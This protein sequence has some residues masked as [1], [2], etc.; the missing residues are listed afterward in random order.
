ML[1]RG[2]F[3][4]AVCL[5]I[6][7]NFDWVVRGAQPNIL[8]IAIDDLNDWTGS[9]GGHPQA[10][11]PNLDRLAARGLQFNNAHCQSPI[12]GPSRNSLLT[13][14]FP[15]TSGLYFL[16]PLDIR[17]IDSLKAAVTLPQYF[18][19]HGYE[20]LA[21]GKVF[22]LN[23]DASFPQYG[24]DFGRLGPYPEKRISYHKGSKNVDWGVAPF[25]DEAMPDTKVA[26]W[27]IDQL[28]KK[29]E[30]PFFLGCG[31]FRPHVPWYVGKKWFDAFP[32][33]SV[34]LPETLDSDGDDISGYA[35][36]LTFSAS[37]PRHHWVVENDE[38]QHSVQAYLASI[39]FVD[40]QLGRVLDALEASEYAENTLIVVWSDHGY[41][42]GEKQ[43]WAKRSL[44]EESTKVPLIFAGPRIPQEQEVDR[45]VGLIDLYPTLVEYA[46]LPAKPH[47]DGASLVPLIENPMA[48][49]SRPAVT[50]FGPHNH[51]IRSERW[52]YIRYADGSEELY[53]HSKDPHEWINLAGKARFN[54]IID[55]HAAWLPQV[56]APLVAGSADSDS[57]IYDPKVVYQPNE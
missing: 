53:D 41:H 47:L 19:K 48:A 23:D 2:V 20:A 32:R 51:A 45:P 50:T 35:R 43:R 56:N 42:L 31:F 46:G 16:K 26:D 5:A 54:G 22:H 25:E 24:G 49:W 28:G 36:K 11:T 18:M 55:A 1:G 15:S 12:C 3:V 44:W 9:Y 13:G 21:A 38:W 40:H 8:F 7:G 37:A 27:T 34:A 33:E 30:K 39:H 29:R 6:L 14:I 10:K 57:P 4:F 17:S 52:R